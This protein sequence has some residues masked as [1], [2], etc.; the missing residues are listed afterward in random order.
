MRF[1]Q[2]SCL[3]NWLA[4][5]KPHSE[6]D[7]LESLPHSRERSPPRQIVSRGGNGAA[8]TCLDADATKIPF[9]EDA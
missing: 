3:N 4:W 6:P 9:S 2:K 8:R 1:P 5:P 7:L